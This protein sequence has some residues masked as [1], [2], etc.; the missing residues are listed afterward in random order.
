M[1]D[2]GSALNHAHDR[3]MP[4]LESLH[5][6]TL[7]PEPH[8]FTDRGVSYVYEDLRD[9]PYRGSY[10]DTIACISTLEHVGMDNRMYGA[11]APASAHPEH[12]AARAIAEVRR[13]LAL[14]GRLFITVPYGASE[15]HG[16]FR[17]YD[18]KAGQ[19]LQIRLVSVRRTRAS[20]RIQPKAGISAISRRPVPPVIATTTTIEVPSQTEPL[21]HAPFFV[22]ASFVPATVPLP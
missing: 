22:S 9:L 7:A 19:A 5:I 13:V 18:R 2:A 21:Q 3:L 6:A 1:L 20:T 16:W 17:Q 12:E 10:F 14:S 8:A 11:T 4:R 15:D